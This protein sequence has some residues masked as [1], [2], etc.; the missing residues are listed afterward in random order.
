MSDLFPFFIFKN[1]ETKKEILKVISQTEGWLPKDLVKNINYARVKKNAQLY[2]DVR[3]LI[4]SFW[5]ENNT[6]SITEVIGLFDM[7]ITNI[8]IDVLKQGDIVVKVYQDMKKEM[9]GKKDD[10]PTR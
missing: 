9:E 2:L 4:Q 1:E 7:A 5:D 3:A 8:K 6:L 10:S